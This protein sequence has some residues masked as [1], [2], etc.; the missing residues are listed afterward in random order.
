MSQSQSWWTAILESKWSQG[1][2]RLITIS[3]QSQC[4]HQSGQRGDRVEGEKSERSWSWYLFWRWVGVDVREGVLL[5]LRKQQLMTKKTACGVLVASE[6]NQP[7]NCWGRAS[8]KLLESLLKSETQLKWG[9][10]AEMKRWERLRI[11]ESVSLHFIPF[12]ISTMYWIRRLSAVWS[13]Q[14]KIA[15][16][17]NML[18]LAGEEAWLDMMKGSLSLWL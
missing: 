5:L 17:I 14:R 7:D 18:G 10:R 4:W 16:S 11:H 1:Q 13:W 9:R 8:V 6:W 12:L 2:S 15:L 3:E